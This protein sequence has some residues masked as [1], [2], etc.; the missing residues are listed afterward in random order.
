MKKTTLTLA[1][2]V[3]AV[4]ACKA[5]HFE[6]KT[7]PIGAIFGTIPLSVEYV[8]N[9]NIGIE[10]TLGYYFKKDNTFSDVDKSSGLVLNGLFKYY[11]VPKN[12][13]DRFYAFP[14]IRYV[15]R[16]VSFTEDGSGYEASY[17]AFG[18][19]F[20]VGYKWVAESGLLVDIGAG[21][22]RNFSGEYTYNDPTYTADGD[23]FLPINGLFRISLGYRF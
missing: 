14:Y 4:F 1:I 19:G 13:G 7:N 10:A 20:G 22:G 16:N 17:T 15:N 9:D 5:Q 12:G 2:I 18:A 11:F 23:D 3:L 8:I 21:V 6:L